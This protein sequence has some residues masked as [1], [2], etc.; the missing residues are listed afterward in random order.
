MG[1]E[2]VWRLRHVWPIGVPDLTEIKLSEVDDEEARRL[3]GEVETVKRTFEHFI[4]EEVV[5]NISRLPTRAGIVETLRLYTSQHSMNTDYLLLLSGILT[6]TGGVTDH[7][8]EHY[9]ITAIEGLG[10]FS[11]LPS[12]TLPDPQGGPSPSSGS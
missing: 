4:D 3:V 9:T 10:R 8:S 5:P 11:E 12:H 7:I 1:P 2:L 6:G